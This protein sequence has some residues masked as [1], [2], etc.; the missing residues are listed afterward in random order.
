[1]NTTS[2]LALV[3]SIRRRV[4]HEQAVV[5]QWGD[6]DAIDRLEVALDKLGELE[7]MLREEHFAP[8]YAAAAGGA[9]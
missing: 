7:Q 8:V 1:M 3:E 9:R 6:Q 4:Q 5:G 2:A